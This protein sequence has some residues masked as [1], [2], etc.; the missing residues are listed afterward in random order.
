MVNNSLRTSGW[1]NLQ[2]NKIIM[3]KIITLN[4]LAIW[5]A[6]TAAFGQ[7]Y[8]MFTTGKSQAYDGFTTEGVFVLSTTVNT[9]FLWGPTN[10][11]PDVAAA[12]G[13]ASSPTNASYLSQ[14][15]Y[16]HQAWNAILDGQFTLATNSSTGAL[17][18]QRTAANGS[19]AYNGG[20]TFGVA[21]TTGNTTYAIYMISWDAQFATPQLAAA[22]NGGYGTALGWSTPFLYLSGAIPASSTSTMAGLAAGFGTAGPVPEPTTLALAV[23]GG[24]SLLACR[25]K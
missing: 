14:P 1:D 15:Y 16:V 9:T 8:F 24:L 2:H 5:L 13:F 11:T 18:A 17:A 10:T 25:R 4:L 7:G 22:A 12:T 20:A 19:I 6:T 21:G 3:K 23:L